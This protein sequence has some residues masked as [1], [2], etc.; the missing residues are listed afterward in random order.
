MARTGLTYQQVADEAGRLLRAGEK[1]TVAKLL[2]ALGG[3]ATTVSRH[4]SDWHQRVGADA[5]PEV[6]LS[7]SLLS[8]IRTEIATAVA[9]TEE[10]SSAKLSETSDQVDELTDKVQALEQSL[11]DAEESASRAT[12][13]ASIH[14][15]RTNR[16]EERASA[17]EQRL[18]QANLRTREI[19]L[20]SAASTATNKAL[21]E[22]IEDLQKALD[23]ARALGDAHLQQLQAAKQDL[24]V[25]V[26]QQTAEARSGDRRKQPRPSRV[27]KP[28]QLPPAMRGK[29]PTAGKPKASK[30]RPIEAVKV[31][32]QSNPAAPSRQPAKATKSISKPK[33]RPA[34]HSK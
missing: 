6:T 18:H 21:R 25:F 4:L 5:T 10:A 3:S 32:S 22:R 12:N 31:P 24:A 29:P 28:G 23:Q 17:L 13:E 2:A 34:A 7:D 20:D 19:E 30:K 14:R 11:R 26:A 33:S 9:R 15:D 1:P 16:S 8:A 27:S